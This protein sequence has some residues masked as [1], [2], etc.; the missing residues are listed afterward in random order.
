MCVKSDLN[1]PRP[2]LLTDHEQTALVC[3]EA[4]LINYIHSTAFYVLECAFYVHV[5]SLCVYVRS[6]ENSRGV[7]WLRIVW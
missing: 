5:Q 7:D 6:S 4:L 2:L 3:L 1:N